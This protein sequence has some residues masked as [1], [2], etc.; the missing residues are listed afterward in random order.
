MKK[1]RRIVLV[2]ALAIG[3]FVAFQA[4]SAQAES[5]SVSNTSSVSS[6]YSVGLLLHHLPAEFACMGF[7]PHGTDYYH[8]GN[9]VTNLQWGYRCHVWHGAPG[10]PDGH[11]YMVCHNALNYNNW[12]WVPG[13]DAYLNHDCTP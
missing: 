12:W 1:L 6:A 7:A 2:A 10:Y 8:N 5:T 11:Y 4:S 13:L 9:L 3:A